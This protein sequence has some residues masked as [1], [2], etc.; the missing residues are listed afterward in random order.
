MFT[1][2]QPDILECEVGLRRH[3]YEKKAIRGVGI[4]TELFQILKNGAVKVPYIIYQ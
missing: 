2:L 4:P 1:H 3:Y